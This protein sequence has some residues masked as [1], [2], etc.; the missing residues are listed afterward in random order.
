MA[1]I[2]ANERFTS[3]IVNFMSRTPLR[4]MELLRAGHLKAAAEVV[5]RDACFWGRGKRRDTQ[6]W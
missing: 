6:L 3:A 4:I 5:E 1:A 2:S